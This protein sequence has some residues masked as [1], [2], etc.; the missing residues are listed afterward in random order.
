MINMLRN[1]FHIFLY[2]WNSNVYSTLSTGYVETSHVNVSAYEF[3]CLGYI[4]AV[5][6]SSCLL[7]QIYPDKDATGALHVM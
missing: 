6:V 3:D 7:F 5:L 1:I 4:D 2:V